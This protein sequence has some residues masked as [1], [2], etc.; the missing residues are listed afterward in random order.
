MIE[1]FRSA[2]MPFSREPVAVSSVRSFVMTTLQSWGVES[3]VDDVCLAA[4]ELA[5]NAVLH[6]SLAGIPLRVR[7]LLLGEIIR[8]EVHDRCSSLPQPAK[9]LDDDESG[10]GISV[11]SILADEWGVDLA[12]DSSGKSVWTEFSVNIGLVVNSE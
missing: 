4:S 7:L 2:Q 9:A 10:R 3:R 5:S 8:L 1:S 12:L 6:T 11:V